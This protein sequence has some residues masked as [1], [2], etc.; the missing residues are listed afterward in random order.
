RMTRLPDGSLADLSWTYDV[1]SRADL[2]IHRIYGAADGRAWS[3]PQSTGVAGQLSTPLALGGATLL[4]AYLPRH[5]PPSLRLRA[6]AGAGRSWDAAE[7]LVLFAAG[8]GGAGDD[9]GGA[10]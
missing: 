4:M 1:R 8:E 6:S 9:L 10:V 3:P 2:P 5:A 7:E